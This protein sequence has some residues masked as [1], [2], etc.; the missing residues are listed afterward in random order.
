MVKFISITWWQQL[1]NERTA[2]VTSTLDCKSDINLVPS[3]GFL[4]LLHLKG[5]TTRRQRHW[6]LILGWD[7]IFD[8]EKEGVRSQISVLDFEDIVGYGRR[9]GLWPSISS[10]ATYCVIGYHLQ[11]HDEMETNSMPF[12]VQDVTDKKG[13]AQKWSHRPKQKDNNAVHKNV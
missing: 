9:L 13:G 11:S 3:V 1:S 6:L 7:I 5:E 12:M 2:I 10:A 4:F 8:S